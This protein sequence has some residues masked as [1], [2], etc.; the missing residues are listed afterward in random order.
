MGVLSGTTASPGAAVVS[1]GGAAGHSGGPLAGATTSPGAVAGLG[2]TGGP[3]DAP[4]LR[5]HLAH[6]SARGRVA[7]LRALRRLGGLPT[8]AAVAL[9]TD[10]SS[11]VVKNA[12]A[13]LLADAATLDAGLAERLL[14]PEQPRH[15]RF[16][17]YRLAAARGAWSRLIAD[18]RLLDDPDEQLRQV[19]RVDVD[20]WLS[21]A[22]TA[23]RMPTAAQRAELAALLDRAA[24]TL[25]TAGVLRFHAGLT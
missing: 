11:A 9:L 5:V 3:A 18:L 10:P 20:G 7:A 4:V 23:Y 16:A 15:V 12:V 8:D 21:Q 24:P 25:R 17:G 2:E 14:A 1:G 13:V 19:A 22:A 6:P